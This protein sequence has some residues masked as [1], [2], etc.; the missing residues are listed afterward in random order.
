MAG[1]RKAY[2]ILELVFTLAFIFL[3]FYF[4]FGSRKEGVMAKGMVNGGKY[5]VKDLNGGYQEAQRSGDQLYVNGQYVGEV[6]ER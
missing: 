5:Y 2:N 6:V 1:F 4:I 3:V